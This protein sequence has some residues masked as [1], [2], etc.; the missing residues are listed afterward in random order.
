MGRG[1]GW[2]HDQEQLL[3]A[4]V[5]GGHKA[6]WICQQQTGWSISTVR[7]AIDKVKAGIPLRQWKG[8]KKKVGDEVSHKIFEYA[9]KDK[10]SLSLR[11][12]ASSTKMA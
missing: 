10:L 5:H 11:F 9:T 4:Y 8:S 7:K 12:S 6:S 1:Q 3:K 2:S